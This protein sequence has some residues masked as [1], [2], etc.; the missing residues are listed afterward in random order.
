LTHEGGGA[1]PHPS[2]QFKS[3]GFEK[4]E[5]SSANRVAQQ[6]SLGKKRLSIPS[7]CAKPPSSLGEGREERRRKR[8]G[9][10]SLSL[11]KDKSASTI[12]TV[13]NLSCIYPSE[14]LLAVDF[15][16]NIVARAPTW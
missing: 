4:K 3:Q 5:N 12:Q 14:W 2:P 11:H 1:C 9:G 13:N 6:D 15:D 8:G 10:R 16:C 7:G